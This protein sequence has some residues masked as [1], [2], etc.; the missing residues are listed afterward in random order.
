M[1]D[2][3][4]NRGRITY[5]QYTLDQLGDI[6]QVASQFLAGEVDEISD[7][8]SLRKVREYFAQIKNM[9]RKLKQNVEAMQ[10]QLEQDPH[11][12]SKLM[13]QSALGGPSKEGG[14][15]QHSPSPGGAAGEEEKSSAPK[16][17]AAIDKQAAFVEYK[18]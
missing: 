9:Y 16:K 18:T 12:A 15:Q 3:L 7:F 10:R 2:T 6:K 14:D 17:R 11:A 4:K 5:D 8:D 1:H 13:S